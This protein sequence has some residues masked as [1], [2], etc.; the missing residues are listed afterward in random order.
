MQH[1]KQYMNNNFVSERET[2]S[3]GGKVVY[4]VNDIER[5]KR[6]V[7]LGSE[8]GTLHITKDTLTKQNLDCLERLL[9]EKK[10]T[11]ISNVIN[12]YQNK[13]Y[14]KDY[15]LFVLARCCSIKTGVINKVLDENDESF[16]VECFQLTL[17]LCKIPT[18]LFM[19]IEL[20]ETINKSLYNTTGWNTKLKRMITQWYNSKSLKDL[21]YHITKY[22]NRNNWTHR[23]VLRLSHVKTS[24]TDTN[25]VYKYI[26]KGKESVFADWGLDFVKFSYLIDFES[27]KTETDKETVLKLI[28]E[29]NFVREHIPTIWLN[30]IDIWYTLLQKMPMTAMLRN[31]N[32]MT[33]ISVFN[34][35][36]DA[37]NIVLNK[38]S[39]NSIIQSKVHPLQ[40]LISLKMY[41][42]GKGEKGSLT[43][44]PVQKIV[45]ALD[46]AFYY[47]FKNVEST[48]KRILLALDVSG[49]MGWTNVCGINCLTAA[50]VATAMSM[51]IDS[52]ETNVT[53]MGFSS[54]FKQLN[55]SSSRRLDDNLKSTND[56]N[57]G[58]TD[59]SLPFTWA[60]QQ[61]R[62]FDTIIVFTDNDTNSNKIKPSLAL[63]NYRNKMKLD[64]KLIVVGLASNEFSI[65]DPNDKNML[66]VC[67]FD[68]STPLVIN[69]FIKGTF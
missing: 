37:V 26:T 21:M 9:K 40:I 4:K 63:E 29:H 13:V 1:L 15:I 30:D 38:L 8:N 41:S 19:F 12:E 69:E 14:K 45:A 58:S 20:Y 33:A 22:Q 43:W 34:Q 39:E 27:L 49:S 23:D 50:E 64:T 36:E 16:K 18:N 48:G 42:S 66:D 65:A 47:S 7:F 59:C 67:G 62:Q 32:K 3:S 35:K 68:S 24:D 60:Q 28:I 25:T 10:Y 6:F 31:L 54:V 17:E 5:L 55:I 61:S 56:N 53:I 44:N 46:K 57:F 51:V 52:Q 2:L 11:E